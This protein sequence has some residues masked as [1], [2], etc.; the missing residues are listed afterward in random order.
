LGLKADR[1]RER[2]HGR[3]DDYLIRSME[4]HGL[5]TN[6]LPADVPSW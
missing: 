1:C 5:A 3:Q 6:E 4:I 2:C